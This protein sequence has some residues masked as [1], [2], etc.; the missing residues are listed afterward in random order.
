MIRKLVGAAA[1]AGLVSI[2]SGRALL[3]KLAD[4]AEERMLE[5][6]FWSVDEAPAA[7]G[8]DDAPEEE[9]E[10][11][12]IVDPLTDEALSMRAPPEM[13]KEQE[14]AKPLKGSLAERIAAR[15]NW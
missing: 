5:A 10:A 4:A 15:K 3:G 6:G 12:P 2:R 13:Q 9:I 7:V 1:A 14:R 11:P 8:S